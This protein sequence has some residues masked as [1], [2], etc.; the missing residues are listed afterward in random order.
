MLMK[1][2]FRL[3]LSLLYLCLLGGCS[4]KEETGEVRLTDGTKANQMI[5]AD[6][7]SDEGDGIRFSTDGPWT[8]EV[9]EAPSTRDSDV[10][11]VRLSRYSDDAAGDYVITV[12]I[13][14]NYT[15]VDRT[16]YIRVVGGTSTLT[17]TVSQKATTKDGELPVDTDEM[18]DGKPAY[19][20]FETDKIELPALPDE[21]FVIK[22]R[23]NMLEPVIQIVL[24]GLTA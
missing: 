4:E 9:M 22:F 5:Y 7:T 23:T 15:G 19:V 2:I 17:I 24:P 13:T 18:Y 14:P 11:W 1:N 12:S 10:S 3:F 20:T 6:D 21:L 16:A 8:A